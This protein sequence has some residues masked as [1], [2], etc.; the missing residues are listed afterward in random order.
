MTTQLT[1]KPGRVVPFRRRRMAIRNC[2]SCGGHFEPLASHH[3]RCQTCFLWG[4]ALRAW[5]IG[6][7]ALAQL[8]AQR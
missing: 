1:G 2:S 5:R 3:T 8:R 4:L 7:A 6:D